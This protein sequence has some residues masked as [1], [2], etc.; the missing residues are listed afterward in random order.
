MNK[1]LDSI[2]EDS[3][4]RM[5][6]FQV[7]NKHSP[8]WRMAL[9]ALLT[10]HYECVIHV[11]RDHYLNDIVVGKASNCQKLKETYCWLFKTIKRLAKIHTQ[12]LNSSSIKEWFIGLIEGIKL[13]LYYKRNNLIKI[14]NYYKYIDSKD[15]IKS[16]GY[17]IGLKIKLN[18]I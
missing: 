7:Y 9:L 18:Q 12:N 8:E 13:S 11:Q 6:S 17:K 14:I 15:Q 2:T 5:T 4:D 10:E 3:D 16:F 1:A